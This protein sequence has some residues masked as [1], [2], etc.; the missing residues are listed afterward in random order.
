MSQA[1]ELT[2]SATRT[3]SPMRT[4]H[5]TE[6]EQ[7]GNSLADLTRVLLLLVIAVIA[8]S[9][10]TGSHTSPAEGATPAVE[11]ALIEEP[12]PSADLMDLS[13]VGF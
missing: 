11:P 5:V 7:T 8:R 4:V 12:M 3:I 1:I 2:V 10:L 13:T 6:H 9:Y